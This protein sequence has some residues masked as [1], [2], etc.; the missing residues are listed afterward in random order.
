MYIFEYEYDILLDNILDLISE[1][2]KSKKIKLKDLEKKI[3]MKKYL[4]KL[5]NFKNNSNYD[6]IELNSIIIINI[7]LYF[8]IYVNKSSNLDDIKTHLINNKIF[9]TENLGYLTNL[10][11]NHN[12]LIETLKIFNNKEKLIELYKTDINYKEIIDMLNDFG[13]SNI[14]LKLLIENEYKK[15]HNMIKL[16]ILTRLYARHYRKK[17]FNLIFLDLSK[18]ESINIIVPKLVKLDYF[19]IESLL[20]FKE[21]KLGIADDIINLFQKLEYKVFD[22]NNKIIDLLLNL[23]I[24]LPI[25]DEFLRYHK[26]VDKINFLKT[27]V[28]KS[29]IKNILNKNF[30]IREYYSLKVQNNKSLLNEM[31]KIFY[32]PLAHRK[33]ILYNEFD[34]LNIIQKI[35]SAGSGSLIDINNFLDLKNLRKSSYVNFKDLKE[36]GINYLTKNNFTSVRYAGIESLENKTLVDKNAKIEFR[37]I[38]RQKP[39]NIVGLCFLNDYNLKICDFKDIREINSNGIEACKKLIPDKIQNKL[40]NNYYW[41]FNK[42]KDILFK[43][44]FDLT[45]NFFDLNIIFKDLL[46]FCKNEI[47]KF[48][49]KKLGYYDNLDFYY[50]KK[51]V[52]YYS[53]KFTKF[54]LNR[55]NYIVDEIIKEK[56]R[57]IKI[58]DDLEDINENK[59]FGLSGE[60]IKKMKDNRVIKEENIYYIPHI[61][62]EENKIILQG[63]SYCQHLIDWNII[64]SLKNKN[65]NLQKE[66]VY[67][68]IKKYVITNSEEEYICK[69]CKQYLDVKNYIVNDYDGISGIDVV[70]NNKKNLS[71][72]KEYEKYSIIIKNLDKLIERVGRINNLNIYVG[73]E[74][75]VKIRREEIIKNIIDLIILHEK[76]LKIKNMSNIERQLDANRKFGINTKYTNF[77]LFPLTNDLFKSSSEEKDKFK[78]IKLNTIIVYIILF[79]ILDIKNRSQIIMIEFS[80]ICNNLIYEKVKN[81]LF[82]DLKIIIDNKLKTEKVLDNDLLCFLIYYFSCNLSSTNTWY[83]SNNDISLKQKSIINTFFD[84]TNSLLEVYSFKKKNYLYEIL[85]SKIINKVNLF[86]NNRKLLDIIISNNNIT[87]DKEKNKIIIK[88]TNISSIKLKDLKKEESKLNKFN[89]NL[90]KLDTKKIININLDKKYLNDIYLNYQNILENKILSLF[91]ENGIRRRKIIN[92]NEIKKLDIGVK[93]KILKMYF[94]KQNKLIEEKKTNIIYKKIEIDKNVLDKFLKLVESILRKD[95]LKIN[96]IEFNLTRSKL[97]IKFDFLGNIIKNQLEIFLDDKKISIKNNSYFNIDVYEVFDKVNEIKLIFNK[98]NLHYLGYLNKNEITDLRKCNLYAKYIPSIKEQFET[99]GFKK[100][101]YKENEDISNLLYETLNNVKMY[102]LFLKNNLYSIKYKKTNESSLIDYYISRI[103]NLNMNYEKNKNIFDDLECV[104]FSKDVDKIENKY[105]GIISKYELKENFKFYNI[106]LNYYLQNIIKIIEINNDNFVRINILEFILK[107]NYEFYINNFEQYYN[108]DIIKYK[109][110]Y[111]FVMD[112]DLVEKYDESDFLDETTD[113]QKEELKNLEIDNIE[114]SE[115]IDID[116]V[117]YEDDDEEVMFYNDEN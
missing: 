113:E 32:K 31:N 110:I 117:D 69:S 8:L 49:K 45:Q 34:E 29:K 7:Y 9:S 13:V 25:T 50:S 42:N 66:L 87:Y 98:Y 63:N 52:K 54:H 20:T 6:E 112:Q 56:N 115:A 105:F 104:N 78:R 46:D 33:A 28:N 58:T 109:N 102:I 80:K 103:I 107:I 3:D 44:D 39:V 116:D 61:N 35:L 75:I 82:N 85:C 81:L 74:Q 95:S 91:D 108:F 1:D 40:N 71:E 96:D 18:K 51:F 17:I 14:N 89:F 15:N 53:N 100:N 30:Q 36:E 86:K 93:K 48:I 38:N 60:I 23:K 65:I 76:T 114:K 64:K 97:N 27:D 10:F 21:K 111:N 62:K 84:F 106:V 5:K 16:L 101:Y 99:L 12:Y 79:M 43:E 4:S 94:S 47:T 59:M 11:K 57:L 37:N 68:F 55:K 70:I 77:F 72:I 22:N 73:N 41:I 88:K 67:N 26:I 92:L 2:L 83:S 24:F 19:N 90:Y